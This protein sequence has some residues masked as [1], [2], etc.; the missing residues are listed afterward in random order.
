MNRIKV[1][2]DTQS[3]VVDFV[4]L[5][6]QIPEDVYLLDNSYNKVN[7]KSLLGCLYS[8]EFSELFVESKSD[9]LSSV[10]NKFL[11]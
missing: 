4:T 5:A 2:L 3:D 7:G 10:F 8:L 11:Y 9:K 1:R 6:N